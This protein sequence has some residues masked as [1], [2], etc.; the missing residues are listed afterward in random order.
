MYRY[1]TLLV[2]HPDLPEAQVR[3]TNDRLRRIVENMGGEIAELQDW[4]MRDL[5]YPIR[6]QVRGT[7]VLIRYNANPEVVR[8]LERTMRISDEVLRFVSV[9][10]VERKAPKPRKARKPRPSP[11]SGADDAGA[12]SIEQGS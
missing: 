7:Y 3:E 10:E 11:T 2:Q 12:S 1:E 4:G 6:K 5:A 9:R 8:E